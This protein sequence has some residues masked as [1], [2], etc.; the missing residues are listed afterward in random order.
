MEVRDASSRADRPKWYKG[1]VVRVAM[2]REKLKPME[3]GAELELF[4]DPKSPNDENIPKKPLIL[5]G[6]SRQKDR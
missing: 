5:L 3:G 6:L 4:D 2:K 1:E